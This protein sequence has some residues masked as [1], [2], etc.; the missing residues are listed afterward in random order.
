MEMHNI[1]NKYGNGSTEYLITSN[2]EL[3]T[4][5]YIKEHK[6]F[7]LAKFLDM[8]EKDRFNR[9]T[10]VYY[11][12]DGINPFIKGIV[13]GIERFTINLSEGQYWQIEDGYYSNK[14]L[15]RLM[16]MTISEEEYY[17]LKGMEY[18]SF[19]D[20]KLPDSDNDLYKYKKYIEECLKNTK[21][22][23]VTHCIEFLS[24]FCYVG[25]SILIKD[26]SAIASNYNKELSDLLITCCGAMIGLAAY[27]IVNL[28]LNKRY[29]TVLREINNSNRMYK[30]YSEELDNISNAESY[31]KSL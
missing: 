7:K 10:F 15:E 4:E 23:K 1:N 26:I 3:T 5:F 20:G 14:L 29:E 22:S 9:V 17:S 2:N 11:A 30:S 12:N 31:R 8:I 28:L 24:P 18:D 13:N 19:V 6:T 21:A 27:N 25:G 16:E